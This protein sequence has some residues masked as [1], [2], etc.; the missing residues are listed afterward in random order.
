MNL[1]PSP[2]QVATNNPDAESGLSD[3]TAFLR[4]A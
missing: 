3:G 4:L 2:V 1:R